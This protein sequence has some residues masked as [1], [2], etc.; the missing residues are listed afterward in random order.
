MRG[1]VDPTKPRRARLDASTGR[2][3]GASA[4]Q[5]VLR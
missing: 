1:R 4:A 5:N 2:R 3:S